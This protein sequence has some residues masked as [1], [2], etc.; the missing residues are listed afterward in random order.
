MSL[1]SFLE[2][3][4]KPNNFCFYHFFLRLCFTLLFPWF[5]RAMVT[6]HGSKTNMQQNFLEKRMFLKFIQNMEKETCLK[7]FLNIFSV[8][9]NAFSTFVHPMIKNTFPLQYFDLTS[10]TFLFWKIML[11]VCFASVVSDN[12]PYKSWKK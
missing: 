12:S 2:E 5:V 6:N 11:H 7:Y 3:Q 9:I 4:F 10:G 8:Y 1:L